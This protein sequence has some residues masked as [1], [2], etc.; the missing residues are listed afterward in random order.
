MNSMMMVSREP[1]GTLHIN[2]KTNRNPPFKNGRKSLRKQNF[3]IGVKIKYFVQALKITRLNSRWIN[4]SLYCLQLTWSKDIEFILYAVYCICC[5]DITTANYACFEID[6]DINKIKLIDNICY[7]E[8][9]F[10]IFGRKIL[11]NIFLL[12]DFRDILLLTD[13]NEWN[14]YECPECLIPCL[15][16]SNWYTRLHPS[17]GEYR[18]WNYR[19]NWLR[20]NQYFFTLSNFVQSMNAELNSRAI[21]FAFA[22]CNFL[23]WSWPSLASEIIVCT[24]QVLSEKWPTSLQTVNRQGRHVPECSINFLIQRRLY[25]SQK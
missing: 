1:I 2:K 24:W 6:Y 10:S 23:G 13:V 11:L 21:K 15:N 8:T 25:Q 20:K 18:G 12:R 19:V 16:I 22:I 17:K 4:E 5:V 9:G 3:Q 7:A 14:L